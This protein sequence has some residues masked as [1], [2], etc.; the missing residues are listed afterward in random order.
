MEIYVMVN[1]L[2]QMQRQKTMT[3]GPAL[4]NDS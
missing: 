1:N 2:R 4:L 3:H